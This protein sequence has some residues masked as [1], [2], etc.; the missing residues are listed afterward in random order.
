MGWLREYCEIFKLVIHGIDIK[1]VVLK[2][3]MGPFWGTN[4]DPVS[5]TASEQL[6]TQSRPKI[7]RGQGRS[8]Y[9]ITKNSNQSHSAM[10]RK[11][12]V[13]EKKEAVRRNFRDA[14]P[15]CIQGNTMIFVLFWPNRQLRIEKG[16]GAEMRPAVVSGI[17]NRDV[18]VSYW[19]MF[20]PVPSNSPKSL[21]KR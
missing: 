5:H 9:K 11:R 14:L 16:T 8:G 10:E 1:L 20:F 6:K 12:K 2:C 17:V 18:P 21:C 15:T 3:I 19:P 7:S 4:F 13:E